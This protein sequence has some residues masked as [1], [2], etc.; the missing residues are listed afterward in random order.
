MASRSP[1][2]WP[3]AETNTLIEDEEFDPFFAL[4]IGSWQCFCVCETTRAQA[5]QRRGPPSKSTSQWSK[6]RLAD[7]AP[8]RSGSHS[9]HGKQPGR[10]KF[11]AL[12]GV[13]DGQDHLH[14]VPTV[15]SNEHPLAA[16]VRVGRLLDAQR[17]MQS[18][19][20]QGEDPEAILGAPALKNM[21]TVLEQ[22]KLAEAMIKMEV[23]DLSLYEVQEELRLQWGVDLQ[24]DT[25]RVVF[26]VEDD[27][28]LMSALV[29]CQERDVQKAW[30]HGLRSTEDLGTVVP[31]TTIWRSLTASESTGTKGDNIE[32]AW[33]L[34]DL[35][36]EDGNGRIWQGVNLAPEG[37]TEVAGVEIP[38]PLKDHIRLP[39]SFAIT[40]LQP[41]RREN[42][43]IQGFR[44]KVVVERKMSYVQTTIISWTPAWFLKRYARQKMEQMPKDFLFFIKTSDTIRER[45]RTSQ[46]ADFY[47]AIRQ[48][49]DELAAAPAA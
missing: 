49:L 48:H 5:P 25:I 17:L 7:P 13:K 36:G 21:E 8:A 33:I 19:K 16:L 37:V 38:P 27:G 32:V 42:G 15:R 10:P 31:L 40:T 46:F 24:G 22:F 39:Y 23:T 12:S 18:M 14:N 1:A 30:N 28:E 43:R 4:K 26:E 20:A 47:Q 34:D 3:S 11:D 6:D 45:L 44:M 2:R 41:V 9:P 29:A 35:E